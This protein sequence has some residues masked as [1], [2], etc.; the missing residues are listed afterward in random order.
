M[1]F[2][3]KKNQVLPQWGSSKFT[4]SPL[5][6]PPRGV[7]LKYKPHGT[8]SKVITLDTDTKIAFKKTKKHR[9]NKEQTS[10]Y[11]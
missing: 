2:T 6:P 7:Q 4:K 1:L 9:E 5:G 11:Y 3:K 10:N 8:A